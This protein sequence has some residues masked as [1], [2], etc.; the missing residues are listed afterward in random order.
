M[1]FSGYVGMRSEL[2]TP[3]DTNSL[4]SA[5]LSFPTQTLSYHNTQEPQGH[6]A[7]I[8]VKHSISKFNLPFHTRTEPLL[9][10][11]KYKYFQFAVMYN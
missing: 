8:P 9:T 11:Y 1:I 2:R 6:P 7:P 5:S 4:L 10:W 3:V